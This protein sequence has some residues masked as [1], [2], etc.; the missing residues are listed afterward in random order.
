[1]LP[2]QN[3]ESNSPFTFQRL[4]NDF[5]VMFRSGLQNLFFNQRQKT[6]LGCK[7]NANRVSSKSVFGFFAVLFFRCS[8]FIFKN[9]RLGTKNYWNLN[10]LNNGK[11]QIVGF[12]LSQF[13]KYG[14]GTATSQNVGPIFNPT[15]HSIR[16]AFQF[17]I[18]LFWLLFCDFF[19]TIWFQF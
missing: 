19:V 1:M 5:F 12:T 16:A 4:V 10:A 11:D 6:V 7:T 17:C 18:S 9:V 13:S 8:F 15:L 2:Q 14:T 3:Q